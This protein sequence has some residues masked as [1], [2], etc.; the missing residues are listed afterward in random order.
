MRAARQLARPSDSTRDH[1][2]RVPVSSPNDSASG[3]GPAG[4]STTTK[5]SNSTPRGYRGSARDHHQIHAARGEIHA[6]GLACTALPLLF[7]RRVDLRPLQNP[8]I[9][10]VADL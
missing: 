1:S 4:D 10:H 9:V 7:F 6:S 8:R 3:M 5:L 2:T